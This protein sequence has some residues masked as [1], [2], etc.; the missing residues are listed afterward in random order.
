MP[1]LEQRIEQAPRAKVIIERYERADAPT[2]HLGLVRNGIVLEQYQSRRTYG[3]DG[4][5]RLC[6][7]VTKKFKPRLAGVEKLEVSNS[8]VDEYQ[9]PERDLAFFYWTMSQAIRR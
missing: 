7:R 4:Y 5:R 9:L 2:Y 1:D 3:A 6:E 8:P